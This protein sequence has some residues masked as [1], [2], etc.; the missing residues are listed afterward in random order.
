MIFSLVYWLYRK[1]TSKSFIGKAWLLVVHTEGGLLIDLD[2]DAYLCHVVSLPVIFLCCWSACR[3]GWSG[4]SCAWSSSINLGDFAVL[5]IKLGWSLDHFI[6]FSFDCRTSQGSEENQQKTLTTRKPKAELA[7]EPREAN[8]RESPMLDF[9]V[10]Q[11]RTI[12]Y[13]LDELLANL[14]TRQHTSFKL[15]HPE[16]GHHLLIS[17]ETG[18]SYLYLCTDLHRVKDHVTFIISFHHLL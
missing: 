10:Y 13:S 1:I 7:K 14:A 15:K 17:F 3:I 12:L 5:L 9:L 16:D 8:S 2:W 6:G 4:C 11:P 18:I